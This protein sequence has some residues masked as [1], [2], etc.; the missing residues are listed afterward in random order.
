MLAV[1]ARNVEKVTEAVRNETDLPLFVKLSPNVTNIKIIAKAAEWGGADAI[2]AVNTLMGMAIDIDF[3]RP[4]LANKTGGLSGPA[5]KP[6]ALRCVWE[7]SQAVEI[8]VI[9][10]GGI[11]TWRDAVEFLMAGAS[12]LQIGTAIMNQG[13]N[14]YKDITLGIE[15]FMRLNGFTNIKEVVGLAHKRAN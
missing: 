3:R 4:I 12:A 9:G 13:I 1:D 10:C 15:K 7:V 11:S 8:P 6:V 2:T 5:I 14:V